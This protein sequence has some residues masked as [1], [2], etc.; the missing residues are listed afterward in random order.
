MEFTAEQVWGCAVAADRINGGYF[1]EDVWM[2]NAV[3]PYRDKQANKMLVKQWLR[4]N[5]FVEVTQ[6]DI[7]KGRE[8]RA[9]INTWTFKLMAGGLSDFERQALKIAQ[10]DRFTGSNML[11]FAIVSCLPSAVVRDKATKELKREIYVSE[12]LT[13]EIGDQVAGDITVISNR[14]NQNFNKYRIVARMGEAFVDFWFGKA[15]DVG[16]TLRIKGRIKF[17][18]DDKTTQLNFVK[19]V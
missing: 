14:Y 6:E 1:K 2:L 9:Y 12:Q 10:M 7:E 8:I 5:D 16:A 11:E 19:K 17:V 15:L 3:P 18:R 4:T 13:G